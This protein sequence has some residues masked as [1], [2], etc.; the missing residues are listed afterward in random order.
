M[1]GVRLRQAWTW[2]TT[3]GRW[4]MVAAALTGFVFMGVADPRLAGQVL[5]STMTIL[6]FAFTLMYASRSNWRSTAPGRALLYLVA[7][8]ATLSAWLSVS[9]WIGDNFT[10][11]KS[12]VR[13]VLLVVLIVM[14]I[15][16]LITLRRI[17]Q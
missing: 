16:L 3:R 6:A 15:N 1:I 2:A 17:Q 12:I 5:Y 13:E 9:F 8:F 14:F 11:A 10:D 4:I 7:M